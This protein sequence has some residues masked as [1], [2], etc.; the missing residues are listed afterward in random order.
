MSC[1]SLLAL[2]CYISRHRPFEKKLRKSLKLKQ[3]RFDRWL[4]GLQLHQRKPPGTRVK[5]TNFEPFFANLSNGSIVN[6]FWVKV[7]H[8][9]TASSTSAGGQDVALGRE[10]RIVC[11]QSTEIKPDA[12]RHATSD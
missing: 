2:K 1:S 3:W 7:A 12:V 11:V 9:M 6:N 10:C 4:T 5:K 8:V